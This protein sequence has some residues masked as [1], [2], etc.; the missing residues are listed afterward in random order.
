MEGS[1]RQ[2]A[3]IGLKGG[4]GQGDNNKNNKNNKKQH[5]RDRWNLAARPLTEVTRHEHTRKEN[6]ERKRTKQQMKKCR[7]T[8]GKG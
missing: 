3:G 2:V 4:S 1:G 6:R 5:S 8:A 7:V